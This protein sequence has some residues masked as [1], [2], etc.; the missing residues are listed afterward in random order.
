MLT[1]LRDLAIL[2]VVIAVTVWLFETFG[3][4]FL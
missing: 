1:I 4:V 2:F 3:P